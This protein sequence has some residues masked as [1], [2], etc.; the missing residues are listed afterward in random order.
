MFR[1]DNLFSRFMNVLFDIICI[2]VLW[3]LF[4]IPVVTAGA[5]TTAAYYAMSKTVRYKTGYVFKEFWHSFKCNMKQTIPLTIIFWMVLAVLSVDIWYVWTNDNKVNSA[6]FMVLILVLFLVLGIVI[7]IFPLLSRFEKNNMD[8]IK[9]AAFVMFKFLPITICILTVALLCCIGIYLM[10]W[11]LLVIPGIYTF[12]L[13]FPM[14]KI[15]RRLM[16]KVEEES[17]EAKK[18]YYQ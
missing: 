8:L 4:S 13:S 5:A 18:W 11:A 16:P 17:E 6:I 1:S 12:F 9:T 7:Y 15:L 10:P 14:E 2:D 3:L